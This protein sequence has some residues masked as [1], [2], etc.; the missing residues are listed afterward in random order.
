MKRLDRALGIGLGI[1]I[2][3]GI[4]IVFVFYGSE[5]TIDAP[6]LSQN[7]TT[8]TKPAPNHKKPAPKPKQPK[9]ST[10]PPPADIPVSGGAPPESGPAHLD[11]HEGD[12]VRLRVN[13]D[14]TID[15]ELLGYGITMTAT[16]GTP[17]QISFTATKTGNFPLIVTASHIA[18]AQ[19]R[20]D[21]R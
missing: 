12:R 20:V 17:T 3:I 9:P 2:G 8:T 11:Y 4:V 5:G 10:P 6:R 16:G 14:E 21:P 13:S 1:L 18:I 19:I 7:S 15:V